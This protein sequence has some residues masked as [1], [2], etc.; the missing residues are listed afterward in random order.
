[1]EDETRVRIV[2]VDPPPP[3]RSPSPDRATVVV[4]AVAVLA[5]IALGYLLG[6]TTGAADPDVFDAAAASTTST[7]APPAADHNPDPAVASPPGVTT[8]TRPTAPGTLLPGFDGTLLLATE[9]ALLLWN[10]G[11]AAPRSYPLPRGAEGYSASWDIAGEWVAYRSRSAGTAATL[12]VGRLSAQDPVFIGVDHF[13]WHADQQGRLAWIGSDPLT[14]EKG[15]YV[16][17]A[18]A[19][20][21]DYARVTTLPADAAAIQTLWRIA[22]WGDWGFAITRQDDLGFQGD[23]SFVPTAILVDP[24]GTVTTERRGLV[25]ASASAGGLLHVYE[26]TVSPPDRSWITD[27]ALAEQTDYP[28]VGDGLWTLAF[29]PDE[30]YAAAWSDR[31]GIA[32]MSRT[33]GPIHYPAPPATALSWSPDKHYLA[34]LGFNSDSVYLLDLETGKQASLDPGDAVYSIRVR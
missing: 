3:G 9:R 5:G 23:G 28:V 29:G 21:V 1:M 30:R 11:M 18:S 7:T 33:S 6:S 14:S 24:A 19:T 2:G 25:I 13:A 16:A 27:L 4:A 22:G 8:T 10:A 32:V 31:L 20:G 26:E 15:L 12:W 34:F 17:V